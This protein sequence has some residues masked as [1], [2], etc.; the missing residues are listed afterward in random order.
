MCWVAL[1]RA[2][3]VANRRSLPCPL[4]RW[5]DARDAIYREVYEQFWSEEKQ[6]FIQHKGSQTLDASRC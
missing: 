4:V 6:A 3:R 2:I 5:L 1:D